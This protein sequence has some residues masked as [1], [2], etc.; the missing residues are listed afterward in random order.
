M[1]EDSDPPLC[2]ALN[3]HTACPLGEP[4][5]T[6]SQV[7]QQQ[8]PHALG[9]WVIEHTHGLTY[10]HLYGWSVFIPNRPSRSA[11]VHQHPTLHRQVCLNR[12]NISHVGILLFTWLR[13]AAS[14]RLEFPQSTCEINSNFVI[15]MIHMC[16]SCDN[17]ETTSSQERLSSWDFQYLLRPPHATMEVSCLWFAM[18]TRHDQSR[19]N[20]WGRS[21]DSVYLWVIKRWALFGKF[22]F[23]FRSLLPTKCH[24]GKH[25]RAFPVRHKLFE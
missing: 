18:V 11:K 8:C 22:F 4:A 3:Q 23:V 21:V 13:Q 12:L 6:H 17:P 16:V 14:K 9:F 5:P 24:S 10:I 25:R 2:P 15:H 20:Y 19:H 1:P 7:H